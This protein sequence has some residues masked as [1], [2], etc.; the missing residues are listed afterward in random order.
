GWVTVGKAAMARTGAAEPDR[1]KVF[2]RHAAPAACCTPC[3][4]KGASSQHPSWAGAWILD[5]SP[6]RRE[7]HKT[8]ARHP[9]EDAERRRD[10][11]STEI[12]GCLIM[13]VCPSR[14]CQIPPR[15]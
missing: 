13:Q 8:S 15:L 4:R 5:G 14:L 12:G 1:L 10:T 2:E 9:G 11:S 7:N 6:L 3:G